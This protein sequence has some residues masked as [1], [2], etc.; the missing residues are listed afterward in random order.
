MNAYLEPDGGWEHTAP[1]AVRYD[2]NQHDRD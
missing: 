1:A 2:L